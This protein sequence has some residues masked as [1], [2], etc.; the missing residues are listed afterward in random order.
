MIQVQNLSFSYGK[1]QILKNISLELEAGKLYAVIGVN[2]SGK[3]TLIHALARLYSA[4]GILTLDGE[5]YQ[6]I[7][8]RQFAQKVALLPQERNIPEISV[9]ELVSSGRYPYLDLSK[10][11]GE[12]DIA[13]VETA[14]R[15]TNTEKI[16]QKSIK[17]ISGGERQRAYIAMLMAQDTPYLLLDEPTTHLDISCAFEVME[18]LCKLRDAG[19]CI[20]TVIHDLSLALKYA[21]E[22]I[23]L[24]NGEVIS[25]STP[26]EAVERGVPERVFGV[27]CHAVPLDGEEYYVPSHRRK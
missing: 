11:L 7:P 14:M 13:I 8:R 21:D 6:R 17:R 25:K 20:V 5:N 9:F 18:L 1:Q 23:A 10:R 22:L 15:E 16:A 24:S 2:G 26:K 12:N 27:S 19:K 4:E 3:T